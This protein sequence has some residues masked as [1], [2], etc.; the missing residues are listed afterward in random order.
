MPADEVV[1]L[2][3]KLIFSDESAEAKYNKVR[4]TAEDE[5]TEIEKQLTKAGE[6]AKTEASLRE[7]SKALEGAGSLTG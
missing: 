5:L 3:E 6:Q 7:S 1:T 2:L 4:S